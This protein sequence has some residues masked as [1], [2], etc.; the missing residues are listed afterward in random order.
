MR[1]AF[2]CL[3]LAALACSSAKKDEDKAAAPA[4]A[5][6]SPAQ[7]GFTEYQRKS[8]A[9]EAKVSLNAIARGVKVYY[10]ENGKLPPA[11]ALVPP[12][13]A[14][15][16]TEAKACAPEPSAWTGPGWNEIMFSLSDPHRYSYELVTS[17]AGFTARA[18]GDLDCDGVF[19][20]YELAGTIQDG[21]VTT[22]P[23]SEKDPLE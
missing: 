4:E 19:A 1:L 6:A 11:A 14:C 22:G 13:G 18:V 23:L 12:A 2:V 9:T 16:K 21:A 5:A 7:G 8:K 20:T 3:F 10:V 17:A 15:C